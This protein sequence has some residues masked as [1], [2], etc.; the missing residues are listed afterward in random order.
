M[1]KGK[2]KSAQKCASASKITTSIFATIFLKHFTLAYNFKTTLVI[3]LGLIGGSFA[4]ALQKYQISEEIFACDVNIESVNLA[5]AIGL[6]RDGKSDLD[7]FQKELITFDLIVLAT[8]LSEYKKTLDQILN[9][10]KK[11]AIVIDL[12]S[13]KELNSKSNIIPEN[14]LHNFVP[15]H[16]IAGSEKSGFENSDPDLFVE[17]KFIICSEIGTKNPTKVNKIFQTKIEDLVKKI[18]AIPDTSLTAKKH[19]EIYAL[20][21]HLPQFLSFLT[22]EFSPE[23]IEDEFLKT[24]FRLDKADPKIWEGEFGIFQFNEENLEKFYLKFFENLEDFIEEIAEG[25]YV[26]TLEGL[27]ETASLTAAQQSQHENNQ[28]N[29]LALEENFP[30]IFFRVLVVISYL[31]I[32]EIKTFQSYAGS[33]FKDFSSIVTVLNFDKKKLLELLS[34]SQQKILKIFDSISS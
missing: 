28:F 17:K 3:G 26:K 24:A 23:E 20:V 18:R 7:S 33:G 2:W 31:K 22:K 6:I 30:E 32:P 19:D 29:I 25:K 10:I 9:K 12:G 5:K 21:S 16:P 8:P 14:L 34:K 4:K 11:D 15:C 1:T 13:I 27:I